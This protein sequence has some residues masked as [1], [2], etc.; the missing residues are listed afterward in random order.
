MNACLLLRYHEILVKRG[1]AVAA[2]YFALKLEGKE[3]YEDELHKG[4]GVY[5]DDYNKRTREQRQ[6][7][8]Q[9]LSFLYF[10]E[11][12]A[13]EEPLIRVRALAGRWRTIQRVVKESFCYSGHYYNAESI[14]RRIISEIQDSLELRLILRSRGI[15]VR[16]CCW[17]RRLF[18]KDSDGSIWERERWHF[19]KI[20]LSYTVRHKMRLE[21]L[22]P[23]GEVLWALGVISELGLDGNLDIDHAIA[24]YEQALALGCPSASWRLGDLLRTFKRDD[25]AYHAYEEGVRLGH[26]IAKLRLARDAD[27]N[28]CTIEHLNLVMEA[29]RAG[30][31]DAWYVLW[32]YF[33]K[34]HEADADCALQDYEIESMKNAATAFGS[35]DAIRSEIE[36]L[37]RLTDRECGG[38]GR[39]NGMINDLFGKMAQTF[40]HAA[41]LDA[42]SHE[43]RDWKDRNDRLENS[44]FVCLTGRDRDL[45]CVDNKIY[46]TCL[47][48]ARLGSSEAMYLLGLCRDPRVSRYDRAKEEWWY[49][50]ERDFARGFIEKD[51]RVALLWYE[52]AAE[53]G[54]EHARG[55]LAKC[56]EEE[57]VAKSLGLEYR[58][59]EVNPYGNPAAYKR[60][61]E[62]Y[63][64]QGDIEKAAAFLKKY[65]NA[66]TEYVEVLCGQIKFGKTDDQA[67]LFTELAYAFDTGVKRRRHSNEKTEQVLEQSASDACK[68]YRRAYDKGALTAGLRCAE[69]L[70]CGMG[71]ERDVEQAREIYRALFD[72]GFA[73]AA[74]GLGKMYREGLL[75]ESGETDCALYWFSRASE[76]GSDYARYLTGMEYETKRR[77]LS[78]AIVLYQQANCEEA[79]LRLARCY[80]DGDGVE[81][82][83]EIAARYFR[84]CS[85][86]IAKME[87]SDMCVRQGEILLEKDRPAAF[88]WFLKAARLENTKGQLKLAEM[89]LYGN[90]V[91]VSLQKAVYWNY[92][93]ANRNDVEGRWRFGAM[94]ELG[95]GIKVDCN[96]WADIRQTSPDYAAMWDEI[97]WGTKVDSEKEFA[98]AVE[99]RLMDMAVQNYKEA[100]AQGH[101]LATLRL[102]L[103]AEEQV[104]NV[105]PEYLIDLEEWATRSIPEAC[106]YHGMRIITAFKNEGMNV[107]RVEDAERDFTI[108]SNAG[109]VEAYYGLCLCDAVRRGNVNAP[110]EEK[111]FKAMNKGSYEAALCWSRLLVDTG[112]GMETVEKLWDLY[113]NGYKE[114]EKLLKSICYGLTTSRDLM[115]GVKN[116]WDFY[117]KISSVTEED[118]ERWQRFTEEWRVCARLNRFATVHDKSKIT[119]LLQKFLTEKNDCAAFDVFRIRRA[120][121]VDRGDVEDK[122]DLLGIGNYVANQVVYEDDR[123]DRD[124]SPYYEEAYDTSFPDELYGGAYLNADGD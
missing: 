119:I 32:E 37:Y 61:S 79:F 105:G 27:M 65:L 26:P 46:I 20:L 55:I 16:G 13:S 45:P 28:E 1:K 124:D 71:C 96:Y 75:A 53:C 100:S 81:M 54:H 49:F 99:H 40:D 19:Q 50:P 43:V 39:R 59:M 113:A 109:I 42:F 77:D 34:P 36:R 91:C 60:L 111:L 74:L 3:W 120:L 29:A 87:F 117:A 57:E 85:S 23:S 103:L 118:L 93:A 41:C 5:V 106:Y 84:A 7:E 83:V 115:E 4:D 73:E 102:H 114:A 30:L 38:W 97:L 69:M 33:S 58:P 8:G 21:A 72:K 64:K 80:R 35:V 22:K 95:L 6:K 112:R 86:T 10:K 121:Y 101:V 66:Y 25:E 47:K 116:S 68:W 17:A 122:F 88:Q 11:A 44:D 78:A 56:H 2:L 67:S 92:C 15:S 52:K 94:C 51:S 98:A 90:G 89:Y 14:C 76:M 12:L 62:Y 110:I 82:D 63:D 18:G 24:Y 107:G 108:A 9:L 104:F 48:A 70:G 31:G 123:R